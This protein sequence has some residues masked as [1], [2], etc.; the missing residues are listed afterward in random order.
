MLAE[1]GG[2][3]EF[4]AEDFRRRVEWGKVSGK[5]ADALSPSGNHQ[6]DWNPHRVRVEPLIHQAQP[7]AELKAT[8]VANNVLPRKEKMKA[9]LEGR[10]IFPDHAFELDLPAQGTERRRVHDTVARQSYGRP[11]CFYLRPIEG[12]LQVVEIVCS[13]RCGANSS[14]AVCATCIPRLSF[15]LVPP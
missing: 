6:H 9:V 14:L 4:N 2:P 5:A 7:G 11:A 3:F 1:H 15:Y 13:D 12:R 8:L 10:G